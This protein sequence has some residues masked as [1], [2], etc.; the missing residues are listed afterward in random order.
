MKYSLSEAQKNEGDVLAALRVA[1]MKESLKA[2]GRFDPERA[3]N[4]FLDTFSPENTWKIII[5]ETRKEESDQEGSL[6]TVLAGF[7]VIH[8]MFENA[9]NYLQLDHFYIHPDFQS[10]GIGG[11]VLKSLL[12]NA[13]QLGLPIRL[14]ALKNSQSNQFYKLHGFVATHEDE[15]DVYYIFQPNKSR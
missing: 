3:R 14:G 1:A 9:E 13:K 4:R 7:F 6:S 2:I 8:Q 5:D 12:E 11:E 10:K 15:W